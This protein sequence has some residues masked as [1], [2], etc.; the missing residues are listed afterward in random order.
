M[1]LRILMFTNGGQIFKMS[2]NKQ[3]KPINSIF[4]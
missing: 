2:S 4:F 1:L 3:S